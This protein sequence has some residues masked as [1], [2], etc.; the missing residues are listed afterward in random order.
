MINLT[1]IYFVLSVQILS[2]VALILAR[3]D[4]KSSESVK[5]NHLSGRFSVVGGA[6]PL[7]LLGSG[8]IPRDGAA[9]LLALVGFVYFIVIR[10]T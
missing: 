1:S 6:L 5:K 7:G 10:K 3:P 4:K 9:V 8:V 2:T